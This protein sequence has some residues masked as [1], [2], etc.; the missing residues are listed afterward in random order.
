M[1]WPPP[2]LFHV[3]DGVDLKV[4]KEIIRPIAGGASLRNRNV[5]HDFAARSNDARLKALYRDQRFSVPRPGVSWFRHS[6]P[7]SAFFKARH[8]PKITELREK[9]PDDE[10]V[11]IVWVDFDRKV[12]RL[13]YLEGLE[14]RYPEPEPFQKIGFGTIH[15]MISGDETILEVHCRFAKVGRILAS[16]IPGFDPE[17]I[18]V[19]DFRDNEP[20]EGIR[21]G[22][23]ARLR[24]AAAEDTQV[25]SE[26]GHVTVVAR[27]PL[28]SD[29]SK[30]GAP[31]G[32]NGQYADWPGK[33]RLCQTND[34]LFRLSQRDFSVV[35]YQT[36]TFEQTRR[37]FDVAVD[38]GTWIPFKDPNDPDAE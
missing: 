6:G 1:S 22:L 3:L 25:V 12:A 28:L 24:E 11:A 10:S 31:F 18:Q 9:L 35:F 37:V 5:A 21:L 4:L 27:D 14:Y 29:I 23:N 7:G 13:A 38:C 30:A 36:V 34:L 8:L 17:D 19:L 26:V 20:A 2:D 32:P 15:W 16:V 33:G